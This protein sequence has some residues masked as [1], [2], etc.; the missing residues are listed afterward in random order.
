MRLKVSFAKSMGVHCPLGWTS[1][2]EVISC[3][4]QGNIIKWS[5]SSRTEPNLLMS[6]PKDFTPTDLDV[7]GVVSGGSAGS[8][9]SNTSAGGQPGR[10]G[11]FVLIC[12]QDGRFLLVNKSNRIEKNVL[13]HNGAI[14]SGR[15]SNDATSFLTAG[16]DGTLKVWSK[17]AMLRSTVTQSTTPIRVARWSPTSNAIL[18]ATESFLTIKPLAPNS[19][20]I[21][22]TAHEGLVLCAAWCSVTGLIASGAE[23]CRYKVWDQSGAILFQSPMDEHAIVALDFSKDGEFLLVGSFNLAR[24]CNSS[25]VSGN[26]NFRPLIHLSFL[27]FNL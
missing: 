20:V 9:V 26:L 10:T 19:K 4:G 1:S 16:E 22:W 23:D 5:T 24:L 21:K 7:L 11:E 15:W 25:G 6:L 8:L 14:V 2:N 18:Y 3:N 13:A 12:S 17:S 27:L